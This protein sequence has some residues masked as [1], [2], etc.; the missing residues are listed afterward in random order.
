MHPPAAVCP[1]CALAAMSVT[2]RDAAFID[3]L[4]DDSRC[5]RC[6]GLLTDLTLT[7]QDDAPA[8]RSVQQ[9]DVRVRHQHGDDARRQHMQDRRPQRPQ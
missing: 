8:P 9:V 2:E 6:G 7:P 3:A 4:P 5:P 1:A